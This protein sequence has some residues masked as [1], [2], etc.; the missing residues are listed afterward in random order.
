LPKTRKAPKNE[1]IC[2]RI[3]AELKERY[4]KQLER[5]GISITT[6]LN[7]KI[8]EFVLQTEEKAPHS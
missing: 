6:H 8:M 4:E 3:N 1:Q 2:F 7:N 5:Y